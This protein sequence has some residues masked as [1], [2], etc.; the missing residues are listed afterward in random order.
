[1]ENKQKT[2]QEKITKKIAKDTNCK[3]IDFI[4]KHFIVSNIKFN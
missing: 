1:M 4:K 3:D 2:F